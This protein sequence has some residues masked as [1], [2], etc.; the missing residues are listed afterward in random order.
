MITEMYM[1][2]NG[3]DMTEGTIVK[4]LKEEGERVRADEPIMEIETDKIVMEA[5]APGSGVLLKKLYREG[6]TVPV[7][8]VIGYIGE[9]GD[10]LPTEK[11]GVAPEADA[12][13]AENPAPAAEAPA[14]AGEKIAA[15]PHARQ[16]AAENGIPLR[17]VSPSGSEG[18]ILASDVQAAAHS[19]GVARAVAANGGVQLNTLTGTGEG[20]RITKADVEAAAAPAEK[21]AAHKVEVRCEKRALSPMRRVIAKRMLES[22]TDIP[23]VTQSTLVDVTRLMAL[24]AELNE[25]RECRIS[26]NDFVLR[27]VAL[28]TAENERIR[29]QFDGSEYSLFAD[30]HIG[31]AVSTPDGLLVPVIR[32]ADR[33]TLTEI[34]CEARRL[35]R[36]A[37]ENQLRREDLGNARLTISNLGMYGV[38]SFTPIINEPESAILGVC[39]AEDYLA[40]NAQ[41]AVETRKRMMLCLTYDHRILNGSEAAE[42]SNR[43]KH[44]LEHPY[45]LLS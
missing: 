44:L 32:N 31:M 29:M 7:L 35:A 43:V 27:A 12:P 22:H 6:D 36:S 26:V 28:A 2:K 45:A 3:M 15:T 21:P 38:H 23:T 41:G 13:A 10:A 16:L 9:E 20:G 42:F 4:W 30:T 37:R 34:S 33:L 11:G 39:A 40:L 19:T 17:C 8:T 24:R 1:P 5:E 18:Q 14:A 25:D